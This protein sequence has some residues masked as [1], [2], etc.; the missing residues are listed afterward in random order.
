MSL[1]IRSKKKGD[2]FYEIALVGRLDGSTYTQ[3]E[4]LID[5]MFTGKVRTIRYD[6]AEL[7]YL[8]SQGLQMFM[9]TAAAIKK[10]DGVMVLANVQPGVK[11]V[12]EIINALPSFSIFQN[13][14]EADRYLDR[15]QKKETKQ[16]KTP[17]DIED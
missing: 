8:S 14:E 15:M 17:F 13:V 3:L 9:K 11:K 7:V 5:S 10:V 16:S 1:E 2:G 12:F 4:T 6:L